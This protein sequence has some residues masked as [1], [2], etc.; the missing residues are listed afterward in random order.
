MREWIE[1]LATSSRPCGGV[2]CRAKPLR[3]FEPNRY[4][5]LIVTSDRIFVATPQRMSF[6]LSDWHA[7]GPMQRIYRTL[8][9]LAPPAGTAESG[10]RVGCAIQKL[11][12]H[13]VCRLGTRADHLQYHRSGQ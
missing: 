3:K 11:L 12:A 8:R 5:Q 6:L 9:D 1:A 7:C 4:R 2:R 13:V 10:L